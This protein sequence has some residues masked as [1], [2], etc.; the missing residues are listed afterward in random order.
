MLEPLDWRESKRKKL[1]KMHKKNE[2][3]EKKDLIREGVK[4][5]KNKKHGFLH[6]LYFDPPP[7]Q[8]WIVFFYFFI[9]FL[10]VSAP[11]KQL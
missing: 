4:K 1:P 6:V 9:P 11:F 10:D 3:K 7:V 5:K 2:V 8:T